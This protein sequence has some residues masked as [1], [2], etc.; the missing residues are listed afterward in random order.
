M[1]LP[2]A[3]SLT[4]RIKRAALAFDAW[5]N[6]SL[7]DGGRSAGETYERF[8]ERMNV[9]SV[10]GWK[11]VALDLTSEAV[12]LGTGGAVLMLALAQPAFNLTSDNWLKAQDLAVTFLDRYG[13]E[14]GRR[15][16][17]HD[18]SLKLDEFPDIM[19]KALV[20]TEDRRFYEHWGIDP[21]GTAARAGRRT[22]AAA[23]APRAA[24]RSP[25]SSPRTCSS[26]T[27][28]RSSARSTRPSWRSGSRATSPR[29]RS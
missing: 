6:A 7:Y 11:R 25:S 8:Q 12:T 16:I 5:V 22:R 10:R 4:T 2:K 3:T 27:S 1:R 9:F 21:I 23:A 17:K 29:T 19:I 13:T 15:G 24:R 26:P 14:V 18:D 20:S 28:A